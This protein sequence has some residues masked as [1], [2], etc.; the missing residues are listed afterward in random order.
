[1]HRFPAVGYT[2]SIGVPSAQGVYVICDPK[3]VV[4][5]VGRTTRGKR[6]LSQRL[7]NHL[8]GQSSFVRHYDDLRGRGRR[9]RDSYKFRYIVIENNRRRALLEAFATGKLCPKHLGLSS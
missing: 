9:L 4:V 3:N 8:R 5:H 7:N 2:E 6:G 1:M